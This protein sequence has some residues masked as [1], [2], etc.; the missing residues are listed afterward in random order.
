LIAVA[1]GLSSVDVGSSSV[2]IGLSSVDVG[3]SSVAIG[4]IAVDVGLIAVA[5]GLIA[6]DVGLIAVDVGLIAVD[7]GLIAVAIGLIAVAPPLILRWATRERI[8]SM[9]KTTT[10]PFGRNL[11]DPEFFGAQGVCVNAVVTNAL[12]WG[13]PAPAVAALVAQRAVYEPLYLKLLDTNTRTRADIAA[14]RLGR[15]TY[16]NKCRLFWNKW[17]EDNDEIPAEEK[18]KTGGRLKDIEPSPSPVITDTPYMALRTAGRGRIEIRAQTTEDATKPSMPSFANL[19]ECRFV[20]LEQGD[21]APDNPENF[22][23]KEVSSR[24]KFILHVGEQNAGK[25]FWGVFRWVNTARPKQEGP[26]TDPISITIG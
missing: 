1:I 15:K 7:V 12:T 5:I 22:T 10:S 19:I 16:E 26:W 3:S 17:I 24:S 25:K 8:M 13:I 9:A 20:V 11:N 18:L 21:I 2:A 14:H 4:L 23:K 6:V